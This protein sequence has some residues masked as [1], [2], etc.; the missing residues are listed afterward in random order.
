ML[1]SGSEGLTFDTIFLRARTSEGLFAGD[2]N[3]FAVFCAGISSG[4]LGGRGAFQ[5]T[6]ITVLLFTYMQG[7]TLS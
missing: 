6:S 1:A 7:T 4:Y 5:V 2:H 3:H